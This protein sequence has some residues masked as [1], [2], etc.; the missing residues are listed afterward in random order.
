MILL[1]ISRDAC[2]IPAPLQSYF[3]LPKHHRLLFPRTNDSFRQF[4]APFPTTSTFLQKLLII[5]YPRS[6]NMFQDL[7]LLKILREYQQITP[8]SALLRVPKPLDLQVTFHLPMNCKTNLSY[9]Q[10]LVT[11]LPYSPKNIYLQDHKPSA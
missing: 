1:Q 3:H 5:L 8:S 6:M 2:A 7:Q 11:P 4:Q 9:L 10:A